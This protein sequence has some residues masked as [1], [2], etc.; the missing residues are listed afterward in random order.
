M[1]NSSLLKKLQ[2]ADAGPQLEPMVSTGFS[3][4]LR[5]TNDHKLPH[6]FYRPGNGHS[7]IRRSDGIPL[8]I[9]SVTGRSKSKTRK[10]SLLHELETERFR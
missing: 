4:L 7:R 6:R 1:A 9:E 10:C 5:A 8:R 2:R 3:K